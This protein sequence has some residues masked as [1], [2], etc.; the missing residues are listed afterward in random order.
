MVTDEL[1]QKHVVELADYPF[2]LLG[3]RNVDL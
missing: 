2:T 1:V 3:G